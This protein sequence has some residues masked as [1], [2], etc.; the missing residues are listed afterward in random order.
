MFH[1]RYQGRPGIWVEWLLPA[2]TEV[3]LD[4]CS[5]FAST[6][7]T[8]SQVSVTDKSDFLCSASYVTQ[9]TP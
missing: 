4:F 3:S 7:R 6:H 2:K 9:D 1:A 5:P 8:P